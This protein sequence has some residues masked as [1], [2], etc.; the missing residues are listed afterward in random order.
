MAEVGG[1]D[2]QRVLRELIADESQ[3]RLV[4]TRALTSLRGCMRP[5]EETLAVLRKLMQT[6]TDVDTTVD[7]SERSSTDSEVLQKTAALVYG[8]LAENVNATNVE[9][10]TAMRRDLLERFMFAKGVEQKRILVAKPRQF[11]QR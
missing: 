8:I 3:D 5:D 7:E 2:E 6:P 4:R 1:P 11:L 9:A 10:A